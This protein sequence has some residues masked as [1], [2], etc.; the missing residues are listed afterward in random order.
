MDWLGIT[1]NSLKFILDQ[2]RNK[3]I[4]KRDESWRWVRYEK[5]LSPSKKIINK[6]RL[7]CITDCSFKVTTN[8]R[9]KYKDENYILISKGW[10][11]LNE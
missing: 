2:H 10:L 7:E 5:L 3:K 11:N 9:N 6:N 4:W 8:K 1:D